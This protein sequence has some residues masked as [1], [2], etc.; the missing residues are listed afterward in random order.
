M[1]V[2]GLD[3]EGQAKIRGKAGGEKGK[4]KGKGGMNEGQHDESRERKRWK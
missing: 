4:L 2:C 1:N 3:E